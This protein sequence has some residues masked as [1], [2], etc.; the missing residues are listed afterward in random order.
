MTAVF[1]VIDSATTRTDTRASTVA[2][3]GSP[4]SSA[5]YPV[6]ASAS[7]ASSTIRSGRLRSTSR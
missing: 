1:I 5:A 2:Y 7:M 4:E 6:K 3:A